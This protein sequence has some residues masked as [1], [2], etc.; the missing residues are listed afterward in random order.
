MAKMILFAVLRAVAG[1]LKIFFL[2]VKKYLFDMRW[3]IRGNGSS[4]IRDFSK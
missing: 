1:V 4:Y 3:L 2:F